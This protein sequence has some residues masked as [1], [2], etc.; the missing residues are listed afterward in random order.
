LQRPSKRFTLPRTAAASVLAVGITTIGV[1]SAAGATAPAG[2]ATASEQ[3][4]PIKVASIVGQL[5]KDDNEAGIEAAV[6]AVNAAGGLVDAQGKKH[7]LT[8]T[9]CTDNNDA[10]TAGQ[11]GRAAANESSVLATID[12]SSSYGATYNPI[13]LDAGLANIGVQLFSTG[14]TG[15]AGSSN[16]FISSAGIFNSICAAKIA[17]QKLNSKKIGV[18]YVN[19]PAGASLPPFIK[20]LIG[21]LGADTVGVIPIDPTKADLTSDAANLVAA[22]PDSV[23]DGLALDQF[24]KLIKLVRQQGN[25]MNFLISYGVTD[26]NQ[27]KSLLAGANNNIYLVDE[28]NHQS[29]GWKQ[30]LKDMDKYNKGFK[31]R[32]DSVA[33]GWLAVQMLAQAVKNASSLD[34]AGILNY[35]KTATVD[36]GG[37]TPP[38]NYAVPG[39]ALGGAAP[40]MVNDTI[41]LGKYKDG[42]EVPVGK[43]AFYHCFG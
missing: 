41:L 38:L 17:V 32:N 2:A 4:S 7:K 22:G 30:F 24:V 34:R 14:P 8:Y 33:S 13:T 15:D 12:N 25:D 11:C 9:T 37:M 19:I 26:P 23:I 35:M 18:P 16:V 39:T 29:A 21:P 5:V 42:K 6:K 1:V 3:G 43:Y 28:Y 27:V 10:N 40:R 20:S 31:D 36:I